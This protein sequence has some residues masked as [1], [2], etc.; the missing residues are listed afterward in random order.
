MINVDTA[1]TLPNVIFLPSKCTVVYI[2]RFYREK[3]NSVKLILPP[4]IKHIVQSENF[5]FASD[6]ITLFLSKSTNIQDI[7][8]IDIQEY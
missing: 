5:S 7:L 6:K 8:G 3:L 4:T 2:H 1:Q